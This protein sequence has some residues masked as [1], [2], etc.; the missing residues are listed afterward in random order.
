MQSMHKTTPILLRLIRTFFLFTQ[1][2]SGCLQALIY[3]YFPQHIQR[4]MM[5]RW[6]SG[7]LA[8]LNIRLR[9]I[10]KPPGFE[11]PRALLVANHISWLDICVLMAACPTRFVAKSEIDGWPVLGFLSRQAGTLFIRR[12][13]RS[14]TLR[15]NQQIGEVLE[16]GEKVVIFPEGTTADGTYL[17]HFH[18]SLLQSAIDADALLFPVAIAYHRANGEVCLEAA[19]TD[20]SLA[21][22]LRNILSQNEIVV[23]LSFLEPIACGMRNRRELARLSEQ[24]IAETL[25][26]SIPHK[27][28][29]KPYD[30][31][32]E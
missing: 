2:A 4:R 26:L 3:P 19:Y 11:I 28:T 30:L 5:Q 27:K 16:K 20:S 32:T 17:N 9:C 23:E 24:T 7:L 1:V 12:A 6:S 8:T 29:E 18:A 25:S 15:I 13:R 14:D 22:S 21:L 10:G 31:P